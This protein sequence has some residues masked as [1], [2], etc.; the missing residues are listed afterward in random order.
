MEWVNARASEIATEIEK[1]VAKDGKMRTIDWSKVFFQAML[2]YLDECG[3]KPRCR[4]TSP[5]VCQEHNYV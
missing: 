1:E 5:H 2:E 4:D 3:L